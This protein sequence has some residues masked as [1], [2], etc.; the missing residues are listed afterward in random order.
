MGL[1]FFARK[2]PIISL[3]M[4][5]GKKGSTQSPKLIFNAEIIFIELSKLNLAKCI[6]PGM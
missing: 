1:I 3:N 2:K 4:S 5:P 6:I